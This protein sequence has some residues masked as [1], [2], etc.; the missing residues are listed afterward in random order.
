[1]HIKRITA[2][3]IVLAL[4][5][6]LW[7][8]SPM[9]P[10]MS[11]LTDSDIQKLLSSETLEAYT[12]FGDSTSELFPDGT[13]IKDLAQRT[14]KLDGA[15][16]VAL[17]AFVEY[18]DSLKAESDSQKLLDVFNMAQA[19]S[20]IKGI[21]YLSHSSNYSLRFFLRMPTLWNRQRARKRWQI[22]YMMLLLSR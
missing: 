7:A 22:L 15:F 1:M 6:C 9:R 17:S 16:S 5:T 8:L 10:L 18:P 12:T 14:E 19:L 21:T 20:T 11:G 4:C 13:I 2:V 3:I